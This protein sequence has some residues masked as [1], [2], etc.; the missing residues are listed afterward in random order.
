MIR[1]I[2]INK[3]EMK[4]RINKHDLFFKEGVNIIAGP[5]GSGK[6]SLFQLLTNF[7]G[8]EGNCTVDWEP[9]DYLMFDFERDN[10]RKDVY[11]KSPHQLL[12]Q[13]CS[14]GESNQTMIKKLDDDEVKGKTVFLD[15]P[16]QAL[17]IKGLKMLIKILKQSLASQIFIASHSPSL[18]L[19]PDFNIVELKDG[20]TL[21]VKKHIQ[22]VIGKVKNVS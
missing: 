19:H 4:D 17:D 16:E 3:G 11:Y 22:S 21:L 14:H 9:A 8:H 15:E 13:Y 12:L 10:P 6:S 20:Y 2:K 5:N 18:I 1:S 7:H